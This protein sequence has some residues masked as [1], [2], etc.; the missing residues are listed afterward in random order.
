MENQKR[1]EAI[2][3]MST[4]I[5]KHLAALFNEDS[6]IKEDIDKQTPDDIFTAFLVA[7]Y[8]LYRQLTDGAGK[9]V[10]DVIDY[11]HMLNKLAVKHSMSSA[12]AQTLRDIEEEQQQA[13]KERAEKAAATR[14]KNN[15]KKALGP[16]NVLNGD[17]LVKQVKGNTNGSGE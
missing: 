13:R 3:R 15:K 12:V 17:A 9:Q 10:D 14:K 2:N 7:D 16:P 1:V 11:T 6:P 8:I 5:S 4:E